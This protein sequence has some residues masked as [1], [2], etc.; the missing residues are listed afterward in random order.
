MLKK[1]DLNT[2]ET[3]ISSQNP[4]FN[5][6]YVENHAKELI[7]NLDQRLDDVIYI[8]CQ[9]AQ[10]KDFSFTQNGETFSLLEIMAMRNCNYYEAILLMDGFIKDAKTG[11]SRILRR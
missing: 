7:M 9:T 6:Q 2:I 4:S 8:Y 3:F 10:K 11:R 5:E 1:V